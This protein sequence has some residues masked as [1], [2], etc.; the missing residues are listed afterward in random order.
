MLARAERLSEGPRG[1][2]AGLDGYFHTGAQPLPVAALTREHATGDAGDALWLSAD[3]AWVEPDLSGAR[4]L[5]C[6]NMGLS[7]ADAQ[8]LAEPLLALF[9]DSGLQLLLTAPDR[10]H[11]R[12]PPGSAVPKF[13]VPE[14]ALGDSLL[15]HLPQGPEGRRW[16]ILQ[17]EVQVLLHQ[18][19]LNSARRA[20]GLPPVNSLWFWGAGVLPAVV[21]S[22]LAGVIG[23]DALLRALAARAGVSQRPCDAAHL[24]A[25]TAG[26]LVDLQDRLVSEID[27]SWW[28]IL[29]ALARRQPLRLSFASGER[30][31][32]APWHRLRFWRGARA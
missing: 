9:A 28:P 1:Y 6:G 18:H 12:L 22:E 3:P 32:L 4:L 30:W 27:A 11:L 24:E 15:Q 5:A 31:Q 25:A 10:W 7:A 16:R 26:W 13:P 2:L 21:C 8:T 19:P 14:Q 20:A 23:E 17:N 29:D